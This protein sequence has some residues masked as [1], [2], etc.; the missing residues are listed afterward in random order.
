MVRKFA[1]TLA[2]A[3]AVGGAAFIPAA[4]SAGGYGY[5]PG[6]DIRADIRRDRADLRRDYQVLGRD[7]ATGRYGA[8]QRDLAD[9]HRDRQDLHRDYRDLGRDLYRRGY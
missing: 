3:A 5:G 7:V 1:L 6:G 9:V 2:T 4:A 8:T